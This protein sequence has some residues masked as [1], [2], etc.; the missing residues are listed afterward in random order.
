MYGGTAAKMAAADQE[1]ADKT[2][3]NIG[4]IDDIDLLME[5]DRDSGNGGADKD[6]LNG[7]MQILGGVDLSKRKTGNTQWWAATNEP[8]K[9]D[10]ALLQRFAAKYEVNGPEKW[11]DYAD[12]LRS[13]LGGWLKPGMEIIQVPIGDGY[14][15]FEM[16]KDE[17]GFEIATPKEEAYI[18]DAMKQFKKGIKTFKDIGDLCE[19]F[20]KRNPRFTGRAIDAVNEAIKKK[21]ND[22]D[23]PQS[24]F[25]NPDE[26]FFKPYEER[27]AIL[28]SLCK[29]VDAMDMAKEVI[30]YARTEEALAEDKFNRDV[31]KEIRYI[32]VGLAARAILKQQMEAK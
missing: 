18:N 8:T 6:I 5:G 29:K 1:T 12:I 21:I 26:F 28:R 23:I 7:L 11:Y 13:K 30:R 32:K 25:E 19:M 24:W 16:R 22:Y 2:K 9:M 17:T 14:K 15:P 20:K 3:I 4:L 31:E 10:P 27:V